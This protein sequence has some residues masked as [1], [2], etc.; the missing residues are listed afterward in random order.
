MIQRLILSFL[1]L[2][3]TGWAWGIPANVKPFTVTNSD[4]TML[5]I[6][7]FGDECCHFYAT[8]DGTPVVKETNGDW[9]LAPELADSIN[10]AW[11]EKSTRLNLRRQQ[12]AAETKPVRHL[13][14]PL[15]ILVKRKASSFW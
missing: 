9:R 13:A 1:L 10:K 8:L 3:A 2:L 12:R 5:T 11:S 7:L 6:T 14:T 4:G 15:P